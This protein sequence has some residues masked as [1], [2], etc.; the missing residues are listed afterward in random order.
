M[1]NWL[2][3]LVRS[4][5][6]VFLLKTVLVIAAGGLL[7][8]ILANRPATTRYRIW[9]GVFLIL[10]ILPIVHFGFT[11]WTVPIPVKDVKTP[12]L[13]DVSVSFVTGSNMSTT[14]ETTSRSAFTTSPGTDSKDDALLNGSTPSSANPFP[15]A[16]L[17]WAIWLTGTLFLFLRLTLGRIQAHRLFRHS[18][19]LDDDGWSFVVRFVRRR[20]G[21]HQNTAVASHPQVPIPLTYGTTRPVV[22]LPESSSEWTMERRRIVLLHEFAHIRRRDDLARLAA[23]IVAMFY[24]F[25]PLSWLVF[26]KFKVEQEKSCDERVIRSGIRPSDYASHLVEL[27][28]GVASRGTFKPMAMAGAAT[29]GMARKPELEGR[30]S[31]ILNNFPHKETS[32]KFKI[33]GLFIGI[34]FGMLLVV[35]PV[36]KAMDLPPDPA[37]AAPA[38]PVKVVKVEKQAEP[39]TP[40]K[41][42]EA[43]KPPKA[44]KK[45]KVVC[46]KITT[47]VTDDGDGKVFIIK[48]GDK[49]KKFR[50]KTTGEDDDNV[51]LLGDDG[52]KGHN[53]FVMKDFK[54]QYKAQMKTAMAELQKAMKL[55]ASKDLDLKKLNEQVARS[56]SQLKT[57]DPKI[58]EQL[59]KTMA[60]MDAKL[61]VQMKKNE[62]AMA[63][64]KVVN[65]KLEEDMKHQQ[66]KWVAKNHELDAMKLE[67]LAK[68]KELDAID[69]E[70]LAKLEE[71]KAQR[72]EVIVKSKEKAMKD[73]ELKLKEIEKELE[74]KHDGKVMKW[75]VQMDTDDVDGDHEVKVLCDQGDNVFIKKGLNS[76][77]KIKLK[78]ELKGLEKRDRKAIDKALK[79]FKK[80]LPKGVKLDSHRDTNE[81]SMDINVPKGTKL[82]KAEE[83]GMQEAIDKFV[84]RIQE[85]KGD[86]KVKVREFH[87]QKK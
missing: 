31:E 1:N 61:K 79:K 51:I 7:T 77:M 71:M 67:K 27:A 8:S 60:E 6:I 47:T 64:L 70:K 87:I 42:A 45:A 85:I 68:L 3:I 82:S 29:L 12:A 10:A 44:P 2:D 25:N 19:L 23:R 5:W 18:V 81:I 63:N 37:V 46:K 80:D 39:A 73:R 84:N 49:V 38:A 41:P 76:D 32:M 54:K 34:A 11:G 48:D 20:L 58:R 15:V 66:M 26:R 33:A 16:T 36:A 75:T 86:K 52:D 55:L 56:L 74:R 13:Q 28:R 40:E 50:V 43:P 9:S 17:L 30:L 22:M 35:Q 78:V 14:L 65:R 53:V 83:K 72:I 62:E 21:L 59:K 69:V 24:W 4:T 57:N